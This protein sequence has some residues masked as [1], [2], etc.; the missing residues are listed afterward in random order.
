MVAAVSAREV[1]V[2]K[3]RCRQT[4]S[5]VYHERQPCSLRSIRVPQVDKSEQ[6]VRAGAFLLLFELY[7]C[8]SN[9]KISIF[10][11]EVQNHTHTCT[12]PPLMPQPYTISRSSPLPLT[13]CTSR[14]LAARPCSE[15]LRLPHLIINILGV[16]SNAVLFSRRPLAFKAHI[17]CKAS[18][19]LSVTI[20]PRSPSV[21]LF[22]IFLPPAMPRQ[23]NGML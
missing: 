8:N 7:F 21:F 15:V 12:T 10:T 11:K 23:C 4:G 16:I 19:D 2:R 6:T 1:W 5:E 20:T 18:F 17:W 9:L 14:C 3:I 22:L 13:K